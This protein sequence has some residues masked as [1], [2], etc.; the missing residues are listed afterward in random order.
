LKKINFDLKENPYTVYVGSGIIGETGGLLEKNMDGRRVMVVSNKKVFGLHGKKLVKSLKQRFECSV[1]LMPD[2]ERFKTMRTVE[3]ILEACAS[4]GLDRHSAIV[5]LGGGVVGDVAGFAAAVYM[6]GIKVVHVP[7]TLLS[8][9]DSSVGG[10]TGV[11]LKAGK[12]LAGAFHQPLFVLADTQLLLTLDEREFNNGMAEVIKHGIALD[13]EYFDYIID[14][15][16]KI[17]ARENTILEQLVLGSVR[18]KASVVVPDEKETRGL[19]ALLNYG[20]TVGHAIEAAGGYRLLKHGEAIAAG[21]LV[22]A[23]TAKSLGICGDSAVK[24]QINALKSFNLIKPLKNLEKDL[25]IK[26]I[27]SD[28]KAKDGKIRF[29]LTKDIGCAILIESIDI[30]VLKRELD[31]FLNVPV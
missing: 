18:L 17:K 25:I 11:D 7:T 13:R 28:K 30:I 14:N 20:H 19:R 24:S 2:G 4:N 12:N 9:V 5:A 31:R 21:M 6:R 26:R 23:N 29:V 1:H 8:Q 16:G 10:K 3:G 22:A 15:A 27:F